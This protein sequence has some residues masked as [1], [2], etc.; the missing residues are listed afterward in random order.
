M[1]KIPHT[2]WVK[3][4]GRANLSADHFVETH[5]MVRTGIQTAVVALF[6]T[7]QLLGAI[8]RSFVATEQNYAEVLR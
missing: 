2:P 6:A 1:T 8:S 4:F 3:A 5:G 7:T